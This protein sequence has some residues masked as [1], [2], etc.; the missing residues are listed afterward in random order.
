VSGFAGWIVL[1]ALL[2]VAA[3]VLV[4]AVIEPMASEL[5]KGLP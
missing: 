4:N 2:A 1:V 3:I 5:Q